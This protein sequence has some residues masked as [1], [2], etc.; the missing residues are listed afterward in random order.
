MF[1][2]RL[3]LSQTIRR[4]ADIVAPQALAVMAQRGYW[5]RAGSSATWPRASRRPFVIAESFNTLVLAHLAY[6]LGGVSEH[7]ISIIFRTCL[8]HNGAYALRT[9]GASDGMERRASLFFAQNSLAF[10]LAAES[11]V[12]ACA[13]SI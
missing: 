8:R 13:P 10:A 4:Q 3:R 1:S 11:D 6:T 7:I 12:V 2:G 5:R 9:K